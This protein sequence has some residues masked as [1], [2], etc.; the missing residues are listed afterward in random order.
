MYPTINVLSSFEQDS[1]ARLT[2]ALPLNIL[3]SM[4][5]DLDLKVSQV[6]RDGTA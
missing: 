2:C 1:I 6:G 5:H 4:I 3:K